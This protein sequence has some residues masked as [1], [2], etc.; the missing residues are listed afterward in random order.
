MTW[1]TDSVEFALKGVVVTV[2]FGVIA[3]IIASLVRRRRDSGPRLEVRKLNERFESLGRALRT[4][5]MGKKAYKAWLKAQKDPEASD[6]KPKVFVLDFEGDLM[7]TATA[8]LREE[9]TAIAS[10]AQ[11]SDEV[12]VRLESPGGAVPHYGLAA[13]QLARLKAHDIKLTVCIDRVA[14]SGGYM[15][16][17]VADSIIAAPFAIVGSIG[18]VAQVPNLHRL[19]KKHDV[20]YE[21]MT[22]GEFKRTVSF[23]G[24]ISSKGRAKFQDQLEET[25]SLFKEFVKAHRPTLDVEQVATGEYWLG[26]RTIELGLVDRLAT[27]DEYLLERAKTASLYRVAYHPKVEWRSRLSRFATE[28]AETTVMKFLSRAMSLRLR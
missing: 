12:V 14:A 23:F 9:V 24:E 11:A 22:A 10:L 28:A 16:A 15:M 25:H 18:V 26:R 5:V 19:L 8:S 7:A 21:E 6:S 27:S 4:H 1:V 3:M 20:D 2:V 13:A 17:C